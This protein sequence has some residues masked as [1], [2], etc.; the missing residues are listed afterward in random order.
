M[1]PR[2][3]SGMRFGRLV[4]IRL[5]PKLKSETVRHW[6]CK[7]DCGGVIETRSTSLV[8]GRAKSCGCLM[9]EM[10]AKR[11]KTHGMSRTQIYRT[12]SDMLNRC[13]SPSHP[14]YKHYGGRGIRVCKRW[15]KFV[16]FF[17]DMGDKPKGLW[18]DRID[19]DGDYKPSNC[20]WVTPKQSGR[21][22]RRTR[23][24]SLNKEKHCFTEWCEKLGLSYSTFCCRVN[25]SGWD[26]VRALTFPVSKGG[27]LCKRNPSWKD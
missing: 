9:R 12:W 2:D 10:M 24:I 18:L 23:F 19:N 27:G 20:R 13:N 15:R 22:T 1:K 17:D 6:K 25:I 14:C 16:R 4:A 26:P 3:L 8:D 5:I 21:N 11:S 7:C